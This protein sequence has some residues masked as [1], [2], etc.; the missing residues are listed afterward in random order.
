MAERLLRRLAY[1]ISLSV[2]IISPSFAQEKARPTYHYQEAS[3]D[4]Y[5]GGINVVRANMKLDFRDKGH[6]SMFF[7]A[8]TK[9]FLGSLVPWSGSFESRGWAFR[10]G[11]RV[12][13]IHQSIAMWR[14]EKETKTYDY[15]KDGSFKGLSELY[16]GKKLRKVKYEE[17]L[18]KGTTDALTATILVM[19]KVSD[20]GN[21]EGESE[22]FDGRRRYKLIFHHQ[23][24]VVLKKTRYNA[25]GGT[26]VECT[27][28]V[29]PMA[30]AWHKKPRG[31]L[32]IQEQGR[33]RGMMPTVWLA[34][35]VENSVVVPVR[36][37]VKTAYGTLFMHMTG[38][39]SGDTV[40]KAGR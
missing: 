1:I 10:D 24:F 28:E 20:G 22:V 33:E 21:C 5:A 32:S 9:G 12:P 40:L 38:Y 29:E 30:G 11:R 19:E 18:V 36:V 23:G 8:E 14:D 37:R 26:A 7:N 2:F 31:W 34:Q 4:V 25:Y 39:K 35:V 13:E 27:V 17:E 6:Y 15:G 16:T 3:Y